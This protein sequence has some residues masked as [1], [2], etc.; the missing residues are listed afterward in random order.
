M[1]GLA[2]G[3]AAA[4][5]RPGDAPWIYDEP[6]IISMALQCLRERTIP[7]HGILG[8]H[9]VLYGPTAV[10]IYEAL[11]ALS[12]NLLVIVRL[13]ALLF[14]LGCG[15]AVLWL[16]RL[17]GKLDAPLAAAALLSPYF[18]LYSR[19][20]WDNNF[21]IPLTAVLAALYLSFTM[22][23]RVWKLALVF[24]ILCLT[25]QA[26]LMSLAVIVPLLAHLVWHHRPW[27]KSHKPALL[28]NVA[29]AVIFCGPYLR[30]VYQATGSYASSP[31]GSV[32]LGWIFPLTGAR[33]FSG[34][35]LDYFFGP[36]WFDF[37]PLRAAQILSLSALPLSWVGMAIAGKNI[38]RG[39]R[40]PQERDASFH[41]SLL[42]IGA[43]TSQC[44]LYGAL[45]VYG[46]PHYLGQGWIFNL[47]F[48]WLGLSSLGRWA[49]P[50]CALHAMGLATVLACA[51][52]SVHSRGGTRGIHYGPTLKNQL[53]VAAP[54]NAFRPGPLG[55][56]IGHALHLRLGLVADAYDLR[57]LPVRTQRGLSLLELALVARHLL[58][59]KSHR[60]RGFGLVGLRLV[61]HE[62]VENQIGNRR[63]NE[64]IFALVRDVYYLRLA[65][66][67]RYSQSATHRI[68]GAP[69]RAELKDHLGW[70]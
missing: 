26:H 47:Y 55:L 33:L 6:R 37:W 40:A 16:S 9:G 19:Q 13:H 32:W 10:W 49:R 42:S 51:I 38:L 45:R 17:I 28:S 62:L 57:F 30:A 7:W 2:A 1:L 52:V 64:T 48:I 34:V 54:R 21:L 53:E 65:I 12:K 25:L 18:W 56:E 3:T 29:G 11:L 58:A 27:L 8:S 43:L 50:L 36:G 22:T 4:I 63:G 66:R 68:N 70:R 5:L 67:P 59:Q 41:M 24:L 15:G 14:A 31:L 69:E 39:Q 46:H 44:V 35:G 20:L 60:A 23:P 61:P